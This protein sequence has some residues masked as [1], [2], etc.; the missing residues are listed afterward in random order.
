ML[1]QS[2]QYQVQRER[3]KQSIVIEA[4]QGFQGRHTP[5]C[6]CP[7]RIHQSR[8]NPGPI[9]ADRTPAL[10]DDAP[11]TLRPSQSRLRHA[12]APRSTAVNDRGF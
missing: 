5:R 6:R 8:W 10:P 1:T 2:L 12:R 11:A 7:L 9:R 4:D 3:C